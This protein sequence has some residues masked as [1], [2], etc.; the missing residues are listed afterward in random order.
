MAI[1]RVRITDSWLRTAAPGVY[2]DA[3][4]TALLAR[5][6]ATGSKVWLA[7]VHVR[8]RHV[9]R[10]LGLFQAAPGGSTPLEVA[11]AAARDLARTAVGKLAAGEGVDPDARQ[12]VPTLAEWFEDYAARNPRRNEPETLVAHRYR[13]ET[14]VAPFRVQVGGLRM[15]LGAV[16]LD[17]LEG[18][19]LDDVRDHVLA[20]LAPAPAEGA[21]V[22]AG[23]RRPAAPGART[24][25]LVLA[26]L[27]TILAD[28]EVRRRVP[29]GWKRPRPSELA[30]EAG[31]D[32][33]NH[34][35]LHQ[36]IAFY[37]AVDALRGRPGYK[38]G[39]NHTIADVILTCLWTG[40][41]IGNVTSMA[42]DELDLEAGVWLIPRAKYKSR[43]KM[44][45]T[46]KVITLVGDVVQLLRRREAERS[47]PWVFPRAEAPAEHIT[48]IRRSMSWVLREAGV[49]H[50]VTLHGLRHSLGT[51]LH[52]SN[53]PLK[54]IAAQLGQ[55]DL[56]STE[57]YAHDEV[58]HVRGLTAQAI[59]ASYTVVASGDPD[60]LAVRMTREQWEA[61][62]GALDGRPEAA[63]IAAAVGGGQM[64]LQAG[65]GGGDGAGQ[66]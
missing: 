48:E 14:Y 12:P 13:F 53:A 10:R 64:L 24:A 31:L 61:V 17:R 30:Q 35:R 66:V 41:R 37:R 62:L 65:G 28:A 29:P 22:V 7:D 5:V 21:L 55:S 56:R 60:Q 2:R 63:A 34:I 38:L 54:A 43:R 18:Y 16:P 32:Q 45:E 23:G 39:N 52:L 42:W 33:T 40:A 20:A 44:R 4:E 36:A 15:A 8:G 57:R 50:R 26:R 58:D 47:S 59:A 25:N 9:R 27:N 1:K 51:W 49:T 3:G 11:T 46:H 19:H 6:S